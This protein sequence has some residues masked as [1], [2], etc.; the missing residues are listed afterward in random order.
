MGLLVTT[1]AATAALGSAGLSAAQL[2]QLP[3]AIG[4]AS[5]AIERWCNRAFGRASYAEVLD[6]GHD[7]AAILRAWPVASVSRLALGLTDAITITHATAT[8]ATV[9]PSY[10]AGDDPR[11]LPSGLT[12]TAVAA[13]S[14]SSS[15]ITF[16]D[17]PTV[18]ELAAAIVALGGG[19]SAE[20]LGGLGPWASADLWADGPVRATGAGAT[21]G[22]FAADLEPGEATVDRPAGIVRLVGTRR[23]WDPWLDGND[24]G[25]MV[26][27]GDRLRV[28]YAAGYSTI[29][30]DV[31]AA[32]VEAAK[33]LIL[34]QATD[35]TLESERG[36][37]YSY[38]LRASA[39]LAVAGLPADVL[40]ALSSYRDHR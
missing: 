27:A 21:I 12:L 29:P 15:T 19:W 7:G 14:S 18:A 24:P 23:S 22:A 6:L 33:A 11:A 28:E 38:Q 39:D 17:E 25:A 16:A 9:A 37:N 4:A 26:V 10:P 2:A 13:G 5:A 3:T 34:G 40:R 20:V 1:E 36:L 35:P 31:Q 8:R 32:T 30:A